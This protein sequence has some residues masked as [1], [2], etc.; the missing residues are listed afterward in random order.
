L[1]IAPA[2]KFREPT[3]LERASAW[4]RR[5]PVGRYARRPLQRLYHAALSART[6]GRGLRCDLPSGDTIFVAPAHRHISWNEVEFRAFRDAVRPG[7]VA[8]DIG[9]NV[10]AYS[11]PLGRW[12]GDTGRVFAFE[13]S[14][15]AY[16]GLTTH[17]RMNGLESCVTPIA[18]AVGGAIG[19][20]PFIVEPTAGEGRLA[21][22][23]SSRATVDVPVTTVDAF[24]AQ[25]GITPDF[26]KV[27]VEGAELDVLRGA[28]ETIGR[29]RGR[30]ALFVEL[31][32]ALWGERGVS[33]ADIEREVERLG[34]RV[35]SLVPGADPWT[36]EGVTA[37]LVA[38]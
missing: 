33:Q 30:L 15:S 36:L 12:V 6:L 9:A 16:D 27:D 34:L 11:M 26:I 37:R 4:L 17:V 1:T 25:H 21:A 10:G 2:N 23:S 3:F 31:H 22:A 20:L 32:P 35:A 19:T 38:R 5:V 14:A 13:P 24:C 18:S 28:R 7:A 8:L 29:T